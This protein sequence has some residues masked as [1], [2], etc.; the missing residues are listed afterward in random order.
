MPKA[1]QRCRHDCPNIKGKCPEHK[2]ERIAW[3]DSKRKESGYLDSA[4]WRRQCRRVLYRENT[5]NGGCQLRIPGVCTGTATQVDHIVPVWYT[6]QD[7]VADEDLQG[8]CK[9]CHAVKS[10]YEGVQAKKIK[11]GNHGLV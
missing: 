7:K 9:E 8:V 2:P 6:K 11:R 5:Y 4:E 10:S 1:P 3:K